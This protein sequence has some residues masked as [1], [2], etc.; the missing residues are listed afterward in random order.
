MNILINVIAFKIGWMAS[1][2]GAANGMPFVGPMV[3]GIAIAIHLYNSHSPMSELQLI[4]MSGATGAICD[5]LLVSTGWLSYPS[6]TVL[7]GFAPYWIVGMWM[8]F[9]TTFNMAFRW[10]HSKTVLAF[11]MGAVFGPL[12]FYF[13]AKIG[14]VELVN[15]V[16]AMASLSVIWALAFPSLLA[17]A[18]RVDHPAMA[19]ATGRRGL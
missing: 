18:K 6:G 17:L 9:A 10:L 8:L 15:P 3:V 4:L 2:L 14:A 12:S 7:S 16:A 5:S 13:G 1:V 19:Y 11:F